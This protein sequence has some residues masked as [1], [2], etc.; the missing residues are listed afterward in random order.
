[1]VREE[2]VEG[3]EIVGGEIGELEEPAEKVGVERVREN[4]EEFRYLHGPERGNHCTH[5]HFCLRLSSATTRP[6]SSISLFAR[7]SISSPPCEI[8]LPRLSRLSRILFQTSIPITS[9]N[10]ANSYRRTFLKSP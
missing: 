7:A 4:Y 6:S 10:V 3:V 9:P 5:S 2:L 1:M 8:I